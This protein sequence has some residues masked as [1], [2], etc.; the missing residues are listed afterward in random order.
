MHPMDRNPGNMPGNQHSMGQNASM[1][2]I[3]IAPEVILMYLSQPENSALHA[4]IAQDHQTKMSMR[5]EIFTL[6]VCQRQNMRLCSFVK[7]FF[8]SQDRLK[9]SERVRE[10][11]ENTI[12]TV[13]SG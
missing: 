7:T 3:P 1:H 11:M 5:Q 10:S 4:F 13:L 2:P 9:D 6:Q 8:F 12:K